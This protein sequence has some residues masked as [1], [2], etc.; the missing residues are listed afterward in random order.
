MPAVQKPLQIA[1]I[2]PL[3]LDSAFHNGEMKIDKT[4]PKYM[5]PG[6]EFIQGAQ[7]A[8]DTLITDKKIEVTIFDSRSA[9]KPV[10]WLIQFGNLE[11]FDLIIGSIRPPDFTELSD[12]ARDKK[13]PLV[14]ATY[15]NDEGVTDN[16]YLVVVNSTLRAHIEGIYSLL[17]QKY[18]LDNIYLIKQKGD[19]RIDN[20]FKK[21]NTAP[22]TP[23]LKVSRLALDSI[24]TGQLAKAIDTNKRAVIIGAGLQESFAT[25][26]AAA[27]YPLQK[28]NDIVLIGMPNWGDFYDFRKSTFAD[29][30]VKYTSPSYHSETNPFLKFLER[31]YF[32]LYRAK[33]SEMAQ[34]GFETTW[35]FTSLLLKYGAGFLDSLKSPAVTPYFDYNFVEV[36]KSPMDGV[37]DYYENKH[38]YFLTIMN[39]KVVRD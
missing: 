3:Y 35:F 34:S 8:F 23:L 16:P 21:L 6:L 4:I 25:S 15:P 14:S 29:F 2:A 28:T 9:V 26:L 31:R 18:G 22:G 24:T 39:G 38:L 17:V 33:P 10:P 7:I 12:F 11:R 19:D 32:D 20:Y 30:P 1:L 36:N 27:L 13:I 5:R 37:P